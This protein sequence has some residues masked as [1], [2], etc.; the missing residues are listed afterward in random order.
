M[1]ILHYFRSVLLQQVLVH[2][3]QFAPIGLLD[4]YNSGGAI[5]ALECND[6]E[7]ACMVK[8]QVRGCGRFGAYSNT[9]PRFCTVDSKEKHFMYN[10]LA[11]DGLLIINLQ[12]KCS[13]RDI[14]IVY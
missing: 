4:M 14:E 12:G 2:D 3:I 11:S 6:G 8:V 5:E 1:G 7:S 10:A 13:F 9:E